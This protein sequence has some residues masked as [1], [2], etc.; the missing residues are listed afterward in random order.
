M[1]RLRPFRLSEPLGEPV[2]TTSTPLGPLA[3]A[4]TVL[5][6]L[7][8][9]NCRPRSAPAGGGRDFP[10]RYS[11]YSA[12]ILNNSVTNLTQAA[13]SPSSDDDEEDLSSGSEGVRT[14]GAEQASD[15]GAET[16]SN[17]TSTRYE[18]CA[19]SS[20]LSRLI[21]LCN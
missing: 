6:V 7:V 3:T 16:T 9:N 12:T 5:D 10:R 8:D 2:P 14:S 4:D 17:G 19:I 11:S 21:V 18:N 15:S 1:R 13:E 20:I